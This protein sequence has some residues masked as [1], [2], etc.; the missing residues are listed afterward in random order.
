M[1][2]ID[3][4]FFSPQPQRPR[5]GPGQGMVSTELLQDLKLARAA[6]EDKPAEEG[7]TC[8]TCPYH[9]PRVSTVVPGSQTSTTVS[10]RVTWRAS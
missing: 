10:I 2:L 4:S 9:G 7:Q 8:L 3:V 5:R 6:L 1:C